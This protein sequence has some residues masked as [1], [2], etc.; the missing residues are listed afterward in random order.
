MST[1]RATMR[2][3]LPC[4]GMSR[5]PGLG[6]L[7]AALAWPTAALAQ[8]ADL[9]ITK[10]DGSAIYTPGSPVTYQLVVANAGPDAV[11]GAAVEDPLPAGIASGAWTCAVT[12]GTAACT[13]AAGAGG[14]DTTVDLAA[15]SEVTFTHTIAVPADRTGPLVNS[16]TVAVPAGATD[17][18]PANNV[19]V[20]TNLPAPT[21]QL[22]KLSQGG[23]GTFTFTMANLSATDAGITTTTAGTVT[24][25]PLVSSVIDPAVPVT[26]TEAA[27]PTLGLDDASCTDLESASTGNPASF[28]SLAGDTLSIAPGNLLPGARIVCTFSNRLRVDVA[29][30]KTASPASVR[31]GEVVTYTITLANN[32]PG[33]ASAVVLSD[34]PGAGQDCT[35]PSTTATCAGSGGATC[36]GSTVPVADLLGAGVTITELPVGGEVVVT[37]QCRVTATGL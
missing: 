37:L 36:P 24:T 32:G 18:A 4:R 6:L 8:T 3:R 5:L 29:T 12:S 34:Q 27:H 13:Q 30:V 19:A 2:F 1:P 15:G 23:T 26:V 22:A 7:L 21:V 9:S 28:G 17:G 35:D 11:T 33:D 20:D 16:A 25:S 10:D 14:I 31:T